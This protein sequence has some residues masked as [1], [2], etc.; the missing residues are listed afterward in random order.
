[1]KILNLSG[2]V[3]CLL[4]ILC[5]KTH[6]SHHIIAVKQIFCRQ[7]IASTFILWYLKT[8]D[9]KLTCISREREGYWR[10]PDK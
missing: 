1:M 2:V 7:K 9:K 5:I 4:Y 8:L 3:P 6:M 10:D